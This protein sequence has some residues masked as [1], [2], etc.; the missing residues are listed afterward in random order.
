MTYIYFEYQTGCKAPV[1]LV[2]IYN[3]STWPESRTIFS[4]CKVIFL[5]YWT[6]KNPILVG[7]WWCPFFQITRVFDCIADT[8]NNYQFLSEMHCAA[9]IFEDLRVPLKVILELQLFMCKL[10]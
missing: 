6:Q 9:N 8:Q 2:K 1:W 4:V 7:I 5:E 3:T 10:Y